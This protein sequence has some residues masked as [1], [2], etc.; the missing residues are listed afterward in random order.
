MYSAHAD[1][2][3]RFRSEWKED[4]EGAEVGKR[5]AQK[6]KEAGVTRVV[7]DRGGYLYHGRVKAWPMEPAKAAWSFR[8]MAENENQEGVLRRRLLRSVRQRAKSV[9]RG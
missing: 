5:I 9:P 8:E 3:D 7:F 2:G 1:D 6:A 4:R